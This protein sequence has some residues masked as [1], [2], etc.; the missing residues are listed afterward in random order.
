MI[1]ALAAV[2]FSSDE[3]YVV[4]KALLQYLEQGGSGV[5]P[6]SAEDRECAEKALAKV[7]QALDPGEEQAFEDD[8]ERQVRLMDTNPKKPGSWQDGT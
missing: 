8:L 5:G 2:P 4:L 6:H 7:N 3:L 1:Q